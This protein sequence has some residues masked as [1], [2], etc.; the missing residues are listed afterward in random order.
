M[1]AT[2]TLFLSAPA[3][4]P[5]HVLA[6]YDD[7]LSKTASINWRPP[8]VIVDTV[9]TRACNTAPAAVGRLSQ[10]PRRSIAYPALRVFLRYCTNLA[11][12][13]LAPRASGTT[14]RHTCE[15]I[16]PIVQR[17]FVTNFHKECMV[18][19]LVTDAYA[20]VRRSALAPSIQ[21]SR[22]R[23]APF[24]RRSVNTVS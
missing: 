22:V 2:H 19:V 15:S 14:R 11:D 9:G 8:T 18:M 16:C 24:G 1:L 10:D 13:H 5:A 3:T 23:V 21:G 12:L 4:V 6:I 7:A 20:L 17:P